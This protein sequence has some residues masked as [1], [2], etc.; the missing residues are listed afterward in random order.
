MIYY[1]RKYS[2]RE[3]SD[4]VYDYNSYQSALQVPDTQP[5]LLGHWVMGDDGKQY[6]KLKKEEGSDSGSGSGGG[7]SV[8]M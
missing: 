4:E 5:V 8:K 6:L 1:G 3:N 2:K 7:D